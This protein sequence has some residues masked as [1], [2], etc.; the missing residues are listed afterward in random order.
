MHRQQWSRFGGVVPERRGLTSMTKYASNLVM[1]LCTFL[2]HT[3][4]ERSLAQHV[5]TGQYANSHAHADAD[6]VVLFFNTI[7]QQ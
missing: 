6:S 5:P 4:E 3:R 1:F 7:L 2:Y